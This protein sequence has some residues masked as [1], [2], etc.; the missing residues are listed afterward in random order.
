MIKFFESSLL[1]QLVRQVLCAPVHCD[2]EG[3]PPSSTFLASCSFLK[4]SA[5]YLLV[6]VV[7]CSRKLIIKIPLES[8][9]MVTTILPADDWV[10]NFFGGESRCFHCMDS[11]FDSGFQWRMHV[12]SP[13]TNHGVKSD[14]LASYSS[15][16]FWLT[17]TRWRRSYAF[18][19]L[20]AHFAETL[21]IAR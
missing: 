17:V 5:Y 7:S 1:L 18:K 3:A 15:S 8:Q 20:G 21:D 2:A 12:S 19:L 10:R 13:V 11:C 6:I 14:S 4:R 9:K 16:R